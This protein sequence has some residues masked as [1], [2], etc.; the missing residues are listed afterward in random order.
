MSA[1]TCVSIISNPLTP[2]ATVT[3]ELVGC[4]FVQPRWNFGD[5]I[6]E[7]HFSWKWRCKCSLGYESKLVPKNTG[8]FYAW[9]KLT[10]F[11]MSLRFVWCHLRKEI[12]KLIT[13]FCE[14]QEV[15]TRNWGR[16]NHSGLFANGCYQKCVSLGEILQEDWLY[17]LDLLVTKLNE[18]DT[19]AEEYGKVME[20]VL[21]CSKALNT[22]LCLVQG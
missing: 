5:V 19:T 17:K 16:E 10:F 12:Q 21:G 2:A 8:I 3:A 20:W 15:M 18:K 6:A 4:S 9:T 14:R 7:W 22:N 11:W 1:Y 13:S